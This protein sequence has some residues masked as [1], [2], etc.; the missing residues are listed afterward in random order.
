MKHLESSHFTTDQWPDATWADAG[1]FLRMPGTSGEIREAV[2]EAL[3]I[4]RSRPGTLPPAGG[5]AGHA[6]V[7]LTGTHQ[8][9]RAHAKAV[10]S[11]RCAAHLRS[12]SCA[13]AVA[14]P[15]RDQCA[16][17]FVRLADGKR[18]RCTLDAGHE[19]AHAFGL[20]A[21]RRFGAPSVHEADDRP[22]QGNLRAP[23]AHH[24]A[25]R[26]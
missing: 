26:S 3:E 10:A 15:E 19:S 9:L 5:S 14:T 17:V 8:G 6:G 4:D 1:A 7:A 18:V 12:R 11:E 16:V 2:R 24:E 25:S 20:D 23:R 13:P 22:T 21:S